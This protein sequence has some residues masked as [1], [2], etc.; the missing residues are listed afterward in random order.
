MALFSWVPIFVDLRKI[1]YSWGSKFVVI[2]FS[3]II[4]TETR[5]F[6]GAE[7]RGLDPPRKPRKLVPHEN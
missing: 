3:F 2:V 4:H 6:V 7:I 1:K 5:N